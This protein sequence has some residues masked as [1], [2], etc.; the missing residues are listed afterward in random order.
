MAGHTAFL[1]ESSEAPGLLFWSKCET[2]FEQARMRKLL[3]IDIDDSIKDESSCQPAS[4]VYML[5]TDFES[6]QPEGGGPFGHMVSIRTFMNS[7]W[8]RHTACLRT[9]PAFSPQDPGSWEALRH[10]DSWN[11]SRME[12]QYWRKWDLRICLLDHPTFRRW[13]SS[14]K[15]VSQPNVGEEGR[16]DV[17]R[18]VERASATDHRPYS[19]MQPDTAFQVSIAAEYVMHVTLRTTM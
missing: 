5:A 2:H 12:A 8:L 4:N 16:L 1:H 7:L 9:S 10:H 6:F 14:R 19:S 18:R 17:L 15:S 11:T 13:V 3:N